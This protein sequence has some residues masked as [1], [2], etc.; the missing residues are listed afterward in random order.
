MSNFPL[1]HKMPLS[2]QIN[3]SFNFCLCAKNL[4]PK[5]SSLKNELN[6]ES[7]GTIPKI[8]NKIESVLFFHHTLEKN[9]DSSLVLQTSQTH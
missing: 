1:S 4:D 6:F 8:K 2:L 7:S 5:K 9:S 3:N